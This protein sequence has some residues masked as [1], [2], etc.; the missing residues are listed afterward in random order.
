[1]KRENLFLVFIILILSVELLFGFIY[2]CIIE[3]LN[4]ESYYLWGFFPADVFSGLI[5]V[6]FTITITFL[7][8]VELF[9]KIKFLIFMAYSIPLFSD[10]A[11]AILNG[12]L[13]E[14]TSWI[15][16]FPIQAY[17]YSFIA[18]L[19]FTFSLT[20]FFVK[21]WHTLVLYLI[22]LIMYVEYGFSFFVPRDIFNLPLYLLVN[23]SSVIGIILGSIV[24]K[25]NEEKFE[26]KEENN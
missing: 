17:T 20:L 25:I 13:H 16:V 10:T 21:N 2:F 24:L 18:F 12:N 6:I 26:R 23:I 19:Y 1:M 22:P 15:L 4:Y 14:I 3:F 9:E 11:V 7:F 8:R 5:F